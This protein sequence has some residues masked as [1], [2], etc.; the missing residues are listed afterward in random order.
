MN[1][2]TIKFIKTQN[3]GTVANVI[4]FNRFRALN[5]F[6]YFLHY[7]QNR[8]AQL[9]IYTTYPLEVTNNFIRLIHCACAFGSDFFLLSNSSSTILF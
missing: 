8:Y 3:F 2:E 1:L 4:S 6:S 9:A 7:Q 5:R